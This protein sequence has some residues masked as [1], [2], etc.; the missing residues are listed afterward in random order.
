MVWLD[1]ES[2]EINIE[3][4]KEIMAKSWTSNSIF[5][6]NWDFVFKSMET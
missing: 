1:L 2:E 6:H 3:Q 5:Y 4:Q